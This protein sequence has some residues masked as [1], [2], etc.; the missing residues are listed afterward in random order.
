M[1]GNIANLRITRRQT[2]TANS[3]PLE[4]GRQE[5]IG[6]IPRATFACRGVNRNEPGNVLVFGP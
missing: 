4:N 2:G 6:M 1:I 5:R 3:R